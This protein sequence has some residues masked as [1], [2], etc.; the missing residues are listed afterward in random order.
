[1]RYILPLAPLVSATFVLA[2][3]CGSGEAG[4]APSNDADVSSDVALSDSGSADSAVGTDSM[5]SA[6]SPDATCVASPKM[7]TA[8]SGPSDTFAGLAPIASEFDVNSGLQKAWGSGDIPKSAAPDVVGAFRFICGAGQILYDDPIVFPCS[9]GASHLHQFYGNLGANAFSTFKS[10][11]T[12]GKS[13]CANGDNPVNRS[14]YWTPAMLD[15]KGNVVQPDYEAVYYKRRPLSDP[16][17]SRKSGD[18]QAEGDC[19]PVPNGIQFIFGWDPTKSTTAK[20]GAGHFDCTGP[21]AKSGQYPDIP[22]AKPNC[23]V[24][25]QMLAVLD[26]PSC[27]DGKYLDVPDHRSHVSYPDYGSWGYLKC[28]DAHPYVLPTF[29]LAIA[30]TVA[31]GDDLSLWTLSSDVNAPDKPHGYT[32]HGDYKEAWDESVKT[33]W[34]KGCVDGLLNCSGGDLGN[35]KQIIG[36]EQPAYGWTNP[37][38]LVPMP[39]EPMK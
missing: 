20:T 29:H 26:A 14:A 38:H 7:G 11:R 34:T 5:T 30:Y 39:P 25:S 28:D 32:L 24:G 27:W 1:M 22:T 31:P 4:D 6:D 15:G 18:P 21:G 17:C 19:V 12:S 10:L 35:G 23:P 16:K 37:Q 8:A 33:M 36:A 2:I 9:P 3:G 13:T